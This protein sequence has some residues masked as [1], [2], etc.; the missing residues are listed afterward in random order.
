MI[1]LV[2]VFDRIGY[3]EERDREEGGRRGAWNAAADAVRLCPLPL[4]VLLPHLS[5]FLTFTKLT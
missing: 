1:S 5:V 2:V 4:L 3:L